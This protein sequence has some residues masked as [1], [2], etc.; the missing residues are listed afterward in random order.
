MRLIPYNI[1]SETFDITIIGGGINGAGIALDA[2][3]RGFKVLLLEKDDFGSGIT[4]FSTKLIH[5]GLRYLSQFE[6]S[7]VRESLREREILLKNAPHMVKPV[8]FSFPIY[9]NG[10]KSY[11]EIRTELFAYDLL[12]YDKSLQNHKIFKAKD[13]LKIEPDI[14]SKNLL[15]G[16][17]FYDCQIIYPE[18]L[19]L[20]NILMAE[21]YGA[22]VL[23]YCK[24][25]QIHQQK[26]KITGVSFIDTNSGIE[27]SVKTKIVINVTGPW[28]DS[29]INL[30]IPDSVKKIGGTK[31]SHIVIKKFNKSPKNGL[32]FLSSIDGRPIF[33]IPWRDYYLIGT[34]DKK[35]SGDPD[36]VSP[37]KSEIEYLIN[38]VNSI[39]PEANLSVEHIL[40]SYSGIRPL[41]FVF[42][43]L[44][45]NIT[46]KHMIYDHERNDKLQGF[47]SII[48]GQITTYRSLAKETVN[49]VCEKLGKRIKKISC[50][51]EKIKF[52]GDWNSL[53]G[54]ENLESYILSITKHFNINDE[55]KIHLFSYY[56]FRA[57]EIIDFITKNPFYLKKIHND[58]EDIIFQI[59]YSMIKEHAFTAIDILMRRTTIGS[60]KTLGLESIGLVAEEM[61][62][63]NNWDNNRKNL[64]IKKYESYID[65]VFNS[66]LN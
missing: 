58:F 22:T 57:F 52:F 3:S 14:E 5:G 49:L 66:F 12:S 31:G 15:A 11:R 54:N 43:L 29:I 46:R 9:K 56:G 30:V 32:Y 62:K 53:D 50:K 38:S 10:I 61:A 41:P 33:V 19:C 7:L 37:E 55:L 47:I 39:L 26:N 24:V 17:I 4:S 6:V 60:G 27:Y 63:Y 48:G 2:A 18:R 42:D 28:V 44:E 16:A 36:N 59:H 34:T 21:K 40:Y 65:K 25:S 23:N 8:Q 51:T 45:K 35:Y 20:D 1:F 64:E 13:F